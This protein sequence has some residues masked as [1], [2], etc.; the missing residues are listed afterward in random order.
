VA[1]LLN[2]IGD[3]SYSIYLTHLAFLGLLAKITIRLSSYIGLPP[4]LIYVI[5][6]SGTVACG[7]ILN[8][9]VERPLIRACRTYLA[10]RPKLA[11]A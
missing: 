9:F 10:G 1:R 5:V 8:K 4:E 6:F 7:C 3:A 11:S 2:V